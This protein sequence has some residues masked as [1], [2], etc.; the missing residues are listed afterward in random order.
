[1]RNMTPETSVYEYAR[2]GLRLSPKKPALWFYGRSI[3]YTQLF[4][5]IDNVAN[6][7]YQMG[8]RP[9]TVVT[10]HLP[11]C[12]QAVMSF[13][14]V[15]KLGGIC[16]MVHPQIPWKSL[17]ENMRFCESEVL[18]TGDHFPQ[19]DLAAESTKLIYVNLYDHMGLGYKLGYLL[20][21]RNRKPAK[22]VSFRDLERPSQNPAQ[23]I[24]QKKLAQQCVVYLNSSGTSGTPKT[25]MHSHVACNNWIEN[26]TGFFH[27]SGWKD[28]VA[29]SVFPLFHGAGLI[30]DLHRTICGGS[31]QVTMTK[32]N[33]KQAVKFIRKYR[34]TLMNAVPLV[35]Q[36]LLKQKDFCHKT[37]KYFTQCFVAG[38]HVPLELKKIFD[39]KAGRRTLHEGYGMTEIVTASFATSQYTDRIEASGYPFPN[40]FIAVVD[41]EGN[42]KYSGEGEFVVSTN[43]MML[44]Y[45]KEPE[46]TKE[47]LFECDHKQ[48]FRTGDYGVIDEDG[49]LYFLDRIKNVIIRNGY[50]IYPGEI[51]DVIRRLDSIQDVSVIGRKQNDINGEKICAFVELNVGE[52]TENIEEQILSICKEY[53]PTYSLPHQIFVLDK[54]PR[55][56]MNKINRVELEAYL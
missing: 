17:Q 29:L 47:A 21:N 28:E 3:C 1:M 31:T 27:G 46:A 10:I 36:S 16:N 5:S 33:A 37:T 19:A 56:R 49:Y 43:T 50:N 6:N 48:W 25:V 54:L 14:A 12:P 26:V 38:D 2:E 32:W 22:S 15:A 55:N 24:D 45:L 23:L 30:L 44:G 11:N 18:I 8:V 40:C 7:L 20:K 4:E 52:H 34:V 13:Y 42:L 51:E 35:Y 39:V 9:G 53:L 41:S